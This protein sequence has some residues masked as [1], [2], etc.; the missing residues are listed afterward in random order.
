MQAER[1]VLQAERDALQVERDALQVERDGLQEMVRHPLAP[2][3]WSAPDHTTFGSSRLPSACTGPAAW[4]VVAQGDAGRQLANERE[5]TRMLQEATERLGHQK[6]EISSELD[7]MRRRLQQAHASTDASTGDLNAVTERVACL[8]A[9]LLSCE[10]ALAACETARGLPVAEVAAEAEA[11][12]AV[13]KDPVS[14]RV[15]RLARAADAQG[16]ELRDARSALSS[17]LDAF[18]IAGRWSTSL[19]EKHLPGLC[20]AAL[21]TSLL[22]AAFELIPTL[23]R[24]DGREREVKSARAMRDAC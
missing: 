15:A 18:G 16:L 5:K 10:N 2:I 19:A 14:E 9:E 8:E 7:E 11:S 23:E 3:R 6:A 20:A 12:V 21:P 1:D 22:T 4:Q 24:T 17:A 13:A